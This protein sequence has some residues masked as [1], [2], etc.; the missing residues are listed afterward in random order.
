MYYAY[1]IGRSIRS[2]YYNYNI[3][4]YRYTMT[5]RHQEGSGR[6]NLIHKFVIAPTPRNIAAGPTIS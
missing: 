3:I 1:I 2:D 4:I 6:I 5:W